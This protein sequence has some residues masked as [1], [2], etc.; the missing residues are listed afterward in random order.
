[1]AITSRA[2]AWR[3]L[4]PGLGPWAGLAAT[5]STLAQ[6]LVHPVLGL[7]D[8]GDYKRLLLPLGLK[9][10]VP[11]GQPLRFQ[12][13]WLRY[14]SGPTTHYAY[15]DTEYVVALAVRKIS[16][17]FGLGSPFD[18]RY[19]GL[20][21]ACLLG[22]TV[23]LIVRALT[24]P[25]W[26]RAVTALLLVVALTD[27]RFTVYLDSFYT[28][29][30]SLLALLFLV[31]AVLH[32]WRRPT[33]SLWWL[34][35][36]GVSA[37]ALIV[38]KSQNALLVLPAAG[39]LLARPVEWQKLRL[40]G[41]W[42]GRVH[43]AVC[44]MVL[45]GISVGYLRGQPAG[46]E[47]INR[48]N[49]VFVE[50]LGNSRNPAQD[51]TD[52]GLPTELARYAGIP[53]ESPKSA[54]RDP[55]FQGFYDKVTEVK[56][57]EFYLA[58]PGRAVELANR[59]AKAA[60]YLRPVGVSPP[61]GNQT[62]ASGAPPY[63]TA[64][65]LCLYSTV[66]RAF[67]PVSGVLYPALWA[68]ALAAAVAL[69]YTS[70]RDKSDAGGACG[71]AVVLIGLVASAAIAM[72][73]ALLGEGAFEMVKHLYLTSVCNALIAVLSIQA[74]G[75]LI[76]RRRHSTLRPAHASTLNQPS[77]ATV[78]ASAPPARSRPSSA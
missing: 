22:I 58:H 72:A 44:A 69:L 38:S 76:I 56:L 60:M 37:A 41:R 49:A 33:L 31:A 50:L 65:R 42:R 35:A 47:R 48:Y 25:L 17:A 43:G 10:Q 78:T 74:V 39:L 21:H 71:L 52:L 59:G 62:L 2:P 28:E 16:A 70:R 14:D 20:A 51:L 7:A 34:L 66:S 27:T 29:P 67:R 64:C 53:V 9:A 4:R 68:G 24:G 32:A 3:R 15:R 61:L 19:M 5:V 30:A 36:I 11:A 55:N 45:I 12:Y 54:T 1:M 8:N 57:A 73:V 6:L 23:W 40:T 26:L 77:R 63:L 13:I 18:L 75:L 46:F